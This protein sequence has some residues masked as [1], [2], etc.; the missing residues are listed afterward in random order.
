VGHPGGEHRARHADADHHA[1]VARGGE[2]TGNAAVLGAEPMWRVLGWQRC[3]PADHA[4]AP[5][6]ARRP[7]GTTN[8]SPGPA[9]IPAWPACEAVV[10][11]TPA[12]AT[13]HDSGC[14]VRIKT[15]LR[16]SVS[17]L[18]QQEEHEYG[19]V[20]AAAGAQRTRGGRATGR[21]WAG[22]PRSTAR[23]GEQAA[24]GH[25][26]EV[27][28]EPAERVLVEGGAAPPSGKSAAPRDRTAQL[29]RAES[30]APPARRAT[31]GAPPAVM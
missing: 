26:A 27:G 21:G 9:A 24:R 19:T 15:C 17:L 28:G 22:D 4:S 7:S 20:S 10:G 25:Q 3:P 18:D 6:I 2:H 16:Y 29:R 1:H 23:T 11:S 14:A 12:G 30:C 5:A 8:E 13:G 31:R